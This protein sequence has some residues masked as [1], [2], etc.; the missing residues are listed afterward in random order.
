MAEKSPGVRTNKLIF[1]VAYYK[2]SFIAGILSV[3][4]FNLPN[5]LVLFII[6]QS[7]H[8]NQITL[9]FFYLN[10]INIILSGFRGATASIL[11]YSCEIHLHNRL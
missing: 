11:L 3:L 6:S 2:N 8:Y 9:Y 4:L 7:T 10:R 1:L 5:A